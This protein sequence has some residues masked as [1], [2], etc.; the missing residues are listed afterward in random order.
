MLLMLLLKSTY[1]TQGTK[2]I[3]LKSLE[4]LSRNL[5]LK[6]KSTSIFRSVFAATFGHIGDGENDIAAYPLDVAT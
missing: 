1:V 3:S 4:N 5:R 2:L 6:F